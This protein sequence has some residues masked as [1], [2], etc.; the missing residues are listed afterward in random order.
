MSLQLYRISQTK[1]DE[2]DTFDSAVVVAESEAAAREIHPDPTFIWHNEHQEWGNGCLGWDANGLDCW[3]H[4][5]DVNV[6]LIG[7][8][9]ERFHAGDVICASFNAG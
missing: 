6:E 2:Y 3:S 1:N 9:D 4:P 7:I 5:K 8:P